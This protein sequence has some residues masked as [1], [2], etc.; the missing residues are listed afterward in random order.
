MKIKIFLAE[1]IDSMSIGSQSSISCRIKTSTKLSVSQRGIFQRLSREQRA[2]FFSRI[3]HFDHRLERN[4]RVSTR[5]SIAQSIDNCISR[6]KA[7]S[8]RSTTYSDYEQ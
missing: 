7:M 3:S 1:N 6:I 8:D 4:R 2:L 5:K